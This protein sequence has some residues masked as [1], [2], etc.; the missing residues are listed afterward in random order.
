[1]QD[2]NL[3]ATRELRPL[4]DEV[5]AAT[6]ELQDADSGTIQLYL[7]PEIPGFGNRGHRGVRQDFLNHFNRRARGLSLLWPDLAAGGARHH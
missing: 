6:M 4:L 5:L 7:Q 1:M 3:Q 2:E